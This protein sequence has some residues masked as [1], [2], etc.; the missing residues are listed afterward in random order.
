MK[1]QIDDKAKTII[2]Y[3][4]TV[5]E[6]LELLKGEVYK[7]YKIESYTDTENHITSY[8]WQT[9]YNFGGHLPEVNC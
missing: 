5:P 3:E 4:A 8:P 2:I 7:E 9:P 6:L 1:Y